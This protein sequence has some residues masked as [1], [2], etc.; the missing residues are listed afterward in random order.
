MFTFDF[1]QTTK[2]KETTSHDING[3]DK[4]IGTKYS[5]SSNINKE[6]LM[7]EE[8]GEK[9]TRFIQNYVN[10]DTPRHLIVSTTNRFNLINKDVSVY[11]HIVNLR[12]MNNIRRINKFLE[13]T[14]EILEYDG[15][16]IGNVETYKLRKERILNKFLPGVN[17][18]YYTLDF[19]LKRVFPK[20]KVTQKIYFLL[21]KG[22]NRVLSKAET[23]GRLYSCG[24]ELYDSKVINGIL[25]FVARKKKDPA[26]D[27]NPTYGP[28]I[29]LRRIG[30]GG[31][32]IKVYKMR[33][34]H[35]YS[36]YLQEYIYQN[37][38]LKEGGKFQNDFRITT[39]GKIMRKFW[40]DELPMLINWA[41]GDMKLF[42][43]RPLSKHFYNLYDKDLQ[44]K[45]IKYRPGLVPPYYVDLPR[46][47]EEIQ[48]SE[49][50][51]LE[52]YEKAPFRTDWV[53]F[54]KAFCNILFK[55][56]HSE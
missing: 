38:N 11:E 14:N 55:K 48:E 44:E 2:N 47:I 39:L 49:R 17:W 28:L 21:T 7:I 31:K 33:T 50:R 26:Y 5:R 52:A 12:R 32:I 10:L 43:V 4:N 23:Y 19:T 45:R 46:T 1:L 22:N 53:Y 25:Y 36:E 13:T 3:S 9:A 16:F 15:F 37:N 34:M 8:C 6:K 40:I 51:Y 18:V 54:W 27:Y 20:L 35:A 56:A 29:K 30:K 42:G 41:K 24:F